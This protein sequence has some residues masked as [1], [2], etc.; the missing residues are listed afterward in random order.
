MQSVAVARKK[1]LLLV[2]SQ[3][4]AKRLGVSVDGCDV[5]R[6]TDSF[7]ANYLLFSEESLN[8][9]Q[10]SAGLD[11]PRFQALMRECAIV[12]KLESVFREEISPLEDEQLRIE[13]ARQSVLA[14]L[15]PMTRVLANAGWLQVNVSLGRR[16]GDAIPAA[17]AL[18][19]CLREHLPKWRTEGIVTH[20]FFVRKPPDARLRFLCPKG[21]SQVA[22]ELEESLKRLQ[23]QG[24]VQHFFRSCYEPEQARFGGAEAMRLVHDYF[25]ADT[26]QWL[27]LQQIGAKKRRSFPAATLLTGVF[28]HLFA[29]IVTDPAEVWDIWCQC[30]ELT[31][32]KG[33]QADQDRLDF[34]FTSIETLRLMASQQ[35]I[36]ILDG[37]GAANQALAAGL[38]QLWYD[39][40]LQRGV[41]GILATVAMFGFN[42]NGVDESAQSELL[43]AIRRGSMA[44][45]AASGS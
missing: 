42:R 30:C 22:C 12:A 19:D 9:W 16:D 43:A 37:Y 2:L 4:E 33:S 24:F 10:A 32:G 21:E 11:H 7:R 29:L 27:L 15:T 28:N 34:S 44:R 39:G 14:D 36:A 18:F 26:A 35:E 41:R 25:N 40:K 5:Q 8:S 3:R 38:K 1:A 20:F 45:I 6:V 17:L 31:R 13:Q 23:Q